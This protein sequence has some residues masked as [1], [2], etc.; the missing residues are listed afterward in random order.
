LLPHEYLGRHYY[1]QLAG[2]VLLSATTWLRGGFDSAA[3][4]LG[5][6][7]AAVPADGEE[8]EPVP[9]RSYRAPEAFDYSR[10]LLCVPRD[11]PPV[12]EKQHY[13]E[14]VARFVGFLAERTR[15]RLLAL[16]TN[17]ED[18][19]Q[20]AVRLEPF[21]TE[22]NIP[23]WW[24]RMRGVAK[25]E[26]G[27]LFRSHVDSVLLGLDTFWHGADFPGST[28][29]YLV[30]VRLPYGVPDRYHHAQCAALGSAEQRR[31]IYLP[32]ALSRFRQGFGRLMRTESDR[33]A[34]F[35]LDRRVL[36][37]RH[38]GFLDELPLRPIGSTEDERRARLVRGD[39]DACLDAALA[40]M[41]M[42]SDVRRRALERTFV[43][44][45]LA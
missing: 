35:V 31:A 42:K 32:R 10:V 22:R 3:A 36:D 13:L 38:R 33:G 43:G 23:F 26:L 5:L 24:Q 2:A 21:F 41:D 18:L 11:A 44:W 28:L 7:R 9:V 1:P 16:F 30:I 17:G 45:E 14:Y 12:A 6:A 34:V 4:Y 39:T 19:A 40:H 37:P 25:E 8:R 20:V 29:E 27:Q 15:G